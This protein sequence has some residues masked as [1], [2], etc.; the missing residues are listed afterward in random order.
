MIRIDCQ[1][2]IPIYYPDEKFIEL[3]GMLK[4]QSIKQISVLIID[5][6]SNKKWQKH[7]DGLNIRIKDIDS[8][9]FNHGGT[10]QMAVDM[11]HDKDIFIFMTQ[12][13]VLADEYAIE[14]LVKAFDNKQI[15]CAYGRQLP[16]KDANLFAS[17]ARLHNYPAEGYIRSFEDR[18]KYGMKAV[19]SSDSFAAYRKSALKQ[20]GGFPV[21]V[22]VSEDMYVTAKMLMHGWNVA[23]VAEAKV[24]HSHNYSMW[25]EFKHYRDIG[26]FHRQE[27]W[28]REIFGEAEGNGKRF[29]ME[30]VRYFVNNSC[31][32]LLEMLIR[33]AMK[34]LGYRMGLHK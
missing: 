25:Q 27:K 21:N 31:I 1:V 4:K 18:K 32:A 6:A 28:I 23:Y 19:F 13:A 30:E 9:D 33:D 8:R 29:V 26:R 10:R 24:Y 3:L 12:D 34:F 14:N 17:F 2:I 11:C 15:G 22:V 5:S 20:V 16:H 7:T